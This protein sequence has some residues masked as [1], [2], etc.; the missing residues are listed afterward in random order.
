MDLVCYTDL[1]LVEIMEA[2]FLIKKLEPKVPP[3]QW[4][5]WAGIM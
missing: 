1:K 3:L 4:Q 5:Y 2:Y